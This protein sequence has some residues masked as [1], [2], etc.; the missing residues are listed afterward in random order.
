MATRSEEQRVARWCIKHSEELLFEGVDINALFRVI[1][2]HD[3]N[4]GSLSTSIG[5]PRGFISCVREN[6]IGKM[7]NISPYDFILTVCSFIKLG[8]S[9]SN[10]I[11]YIDNSK[12]FSYYS[13]DNT[14]RGFAR[15]MMAFKKIFPEIENKVLYQTIIK[16]FDGYNVGSYSS[17]SRNYSRLDESEYDL[18]AICIYEMDCDL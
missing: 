2:K 1:I 3:V 7:D 13:F 4:V 11:I 6:K 8:N 10:R 15:L 12:R 14:P 16:A 9:P 5:R 17:F 18:L